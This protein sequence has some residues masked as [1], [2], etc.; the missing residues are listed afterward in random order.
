MNYIKRYLTRKSIVT[1]RNRLSSALANDYSRSDYYTV[2]QVNATLNRCNI[3]RKNEIFAFAI[4]CTK[5]DFDNN[6]ENHSL[7]DDYDSLR[8]TIGDLI[9]NGSHDYKQKELSSPRSSRSHH[10]KSH[11]GPGAEGGGSGD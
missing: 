11:D 1:L 6:V 2:K 7:G 8:D 4:F 3:S 5:D 9:F 10:I